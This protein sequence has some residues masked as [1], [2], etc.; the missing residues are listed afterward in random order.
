MRLLAVVL[1]L[2]LSVPSWA[3]SHPT[4]PILLWGFQRG[5]EPLA[6]STREVQGWLEST[7]T[8][9]WSEVNVLEPESRL[10]SCQGQACAALVRKLCPAVAQPAPKAQTAPAAQGMS[11]AHGRARIMGGFVEQGPAH[12]VTR[13][14]LWIFDPDSAQTAFH[15]DYCQTCDLTSA[16]KVSA[17]ELAQHPSFGLPPTSTPSYCLG[18]AATA[19]LAPPARSGKLFWVVYGKELLRPAITAVVRRAVQ[20]AGPELQ[21]QHVGREYTL[22]VLKRIVARQPGAQVLVT[23]IQASGAVELFMYDDA[24][25]QTEIHQVQCA[26]CGREELLEQIRLGALRLL[27]HCFGDSCA[28]LGRGRAPAEACRPLEPPACGQAEP[29]AA[30]TFSSPDAGSPAPQPESRSLLTAS[31]SAA[32]LT[33]GAVWSIFAAGAAT[34]LALLAANYSGP[35]QYQGAGFTVS[36]RLLPAVGASAGLS[37]LALGVAIPTTILIDRAASPRR[38][39]PVVSAAPPSATRW[40]LCPVE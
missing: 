18:D 27:S 15:D 10:L 8:K 36:N 38:V 6:D 9:P 30:L 7:V 39:A 14:R 26:G 16:L 37:I 31:P 25:E 22:P 4:P 28:H 13:M 24:T 33:K 21:V 3:D 17:A 23:E 40:L 2:C 1:M 12:T 32:R 11:A 20:Q 5:C 35:G 19:Q 34:T 29:L